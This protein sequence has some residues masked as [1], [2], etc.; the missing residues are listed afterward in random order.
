[1][2]FLCFRNRFGSSDGYELTAGV[3]GTRAKIE[4]PVC[5]RCDGHV[6]LNDHYRMP[7]VGQLMK[8]LDE[9]PLAGFRKGN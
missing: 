1:M 4:N 9:L 3:S 2:R 6:V 5:F 8:D 7:F